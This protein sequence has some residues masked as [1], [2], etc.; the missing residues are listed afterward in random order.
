MKRLRP[1]RAEG[2]A[3]VLVGAF[4][5]ALIVYPPMVG[6]ADNGDFFRLM[7]WGKFEYLPQTDEDRYVGWIHREFQITK[8]PLLSWR[9]YPSSEAIFPICEN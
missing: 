4:A 7:Y 6:L 3:L 5:F 8:N 2:L 1:D 9:G